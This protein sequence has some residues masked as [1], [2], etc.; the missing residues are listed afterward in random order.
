MKQE[1]NKR[2]MVGGRVVPLYWWSD[3][4]NFGDALSPILVE[5]LGGPVANARKMRHA[6]LLAI[7]SILQGIYRESRSVC[8]LKGL[9]RRLLSLR[10][11]VHTVWGS[12]IHLPP[13]GRVSLDL[14]PGRIRVSALR[15][16]ITRDFMR[17]FL[18]ARFCD[19]EAVPLG[20]PGLL[21][22]K[23]LPG[24][25]TPRYA[26]GVMVHFADSVVGDYLV[27][28]LRAH[29]GDALCVLDVAAP[30]PLETLRRM[31]QCET[32]LSSAMHGNIVA[33][34]LGIPNKVVCLSYRGFAGEAWRFKYDDYYSVFGQEARPWTLT[35]AMAALPDLPRRIARAYSIPRERTLAIQEALLRAFPHDLWA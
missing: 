33:D 29:F 30:D 7:G 32:V 12:G 21:A 13:R 11:P 8:D 22:G 23:L 10:L 14:S 34:A 15:G 3:V 24:P 28:C 6:A 1:D 16:S 18:G 4:R 31:A 5:R 20:D 26:V 19:W 2:E 25:A 35:E 9:R 17:Q 27:A